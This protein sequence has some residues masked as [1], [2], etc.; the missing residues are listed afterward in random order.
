[1]NPPLDQYGGIAPAKAD[2][3]GF[4]HTKK[5]SDRWWLIDP[6]GGRFIHVA[7]AALAPGK[8]ESNLALMREKFG[9]NAGWAREAVGLVKRNGFNGAGAWSDTETLHAAPE[10]IAYTMIWNFMSNY[11]K[12]R[13]D[14]Y[15]ASG[16]AGYPNGVCF[17]F[18]PEFEKFC[19]RYAQQLAATKDDPWL[20]G[21]FS[22]N[23]LPFNSKALENYLGLPESDPGRRA[24][25][26]WLA[27][28]HSGPITAADREE[29]VSFMVERYFRITTQAI[30]KYD[31]N[32][33]CLGSRFF[34]GITK[35]PV[36]WTAAG[37]YVDVVS[38]NF[39]NA[40]EPNPEHMRIW[41]EAAGKPFMITEFYT[42]GMD[43]GAANTSGAGWCVPTQQDRGF[44]YQNFTLALLESKGCV[45]WHW[46]R[47]M[48]ND[49]ADLTA[50]PSN[51]T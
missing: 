44:F 31:P 1:M 13:G 47:Y 38:L 40:W 3:T 17:V 26:A 15:Q 34:G 43:S 37:K 21:H 50:D 22:D 14:V 48:D 16:H 5:I 32:H 23:E 6:D 20:L 51:R 11:G 33:L 27:A 10:H 46:F 25:E 39:Y 49:P 29:F 4:F 42:K 30:R 45:G 8:T 28:R 9:D 41:A 24:A 19:D 35:K 12:E 2:A 36:L 18:D 7:V